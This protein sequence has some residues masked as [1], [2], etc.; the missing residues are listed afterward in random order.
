MQVGVMDEYLEITV[1]TQQTATPVCI[2]TQIQV[3]VNKLGF[4]INLVYL[5]INAIM[6][7]LVSTPQ[8][9]KHRGPAKNTL[10]CPQV[11]QFMLGVLKT[12]LFVR[13]GMEVQIA[14]L[15]KQQ[16]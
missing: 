1:S 8:I 12:Y 5:Q 6:I 16:K 15:N 13:M 11:L 7:F 14:P 9:S 3:H 2:A 4:Q 10:V